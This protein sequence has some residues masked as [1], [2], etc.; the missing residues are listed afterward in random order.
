[1]V[2]LDFESLLREVWVGR[3]AFFRKIGLTLVNDSTAKRDLS[4]IQVAT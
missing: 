1:M 2:M 3:G 4:N